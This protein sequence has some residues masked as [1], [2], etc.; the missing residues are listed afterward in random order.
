MDDKLDGARAR[1]AAFPPRFARAGLFAIAVIAGSLAGV[2]AARFVTLHAAPVRGGHA[3]AAQLVGQSGSAPPSFA[4]LVETV[5]PAVIGVQT[6]LA[7]SADDDQGRPQSPLDPFARP[8]DPR[9]PNGPRKQRPGRSL[10]AQGS[11]FFISADGYAVTNNHVVEG[12]SSVQVQTDDRKTYT[13]KVVGAD[14]LSDIALLKV[15]G[16]NDFTHV[17][18]AD[19]APRVGEWVLAVGNPFGLG[20]TVT[21]GIVSARERDIGAESSDRLIQ[22]DAPINKGDSGGPSFNL[23]GR[24]IGVNTMIFSPSGGS[25]G[26]AFAIPADAVKM[27]VAELRDK[28]TVTRG[29]LGVQ[30]QQV[31]PEIADTLGLKDTKGALVAEPQP[32]SPAATAGIAPGDVI[33]SIDGAPIKD[34]KDLSKTIGG[35]APGTA[36]KIG[37]RREGEEKTITITL[38]QRPAKQQASA[39]PGSAPDN[40]PK[41]APSNE[42]TGRAAAGDP[43]LGLRLAPASRMPGSGDQ[44][45][46]VTGVDPTG[47]AAEE[48]VELGDVI[49][50]VGG[51]SVSSPEEM[52]NHLRDARRDGRRTVLL[53]LR[54]GDSTRFVALPTG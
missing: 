36:V 6:K 18:L 44:G 12:N 53:R 27:V 9:S 45:L 3:I 46:V 4:D 51:K 54:S 50:E 16:R 41:N 22:I 37:V 33:A 43:D 1:R 39:K 48:G 30:A 32:D 15:D 38:G 25:I 2:T 24:V 26:I 11:G 14:P 42:T 7:E 17:E 13:A 31:T 5:K 34:A 49:L 35:I 19:R 10:T 29:W 40:A 23:E 52:Q 8:L 20:G 47:V 21:A 28:G